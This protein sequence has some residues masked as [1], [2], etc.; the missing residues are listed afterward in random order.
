MI[1]KFKQVVSA[2][3]KVAFDG[4]Y[5]RLVVESTSNIQYLLEF[6]YIPDKKFNEITRFEI[7]NNGYNADQEQ[8]LN[9]IPNNDMYFDA[10]REFILKKYGGVLKD[11]ALSFAASFDTSSNKY[12][13]LAFTSNTQRYE[14]IVGV[15][16]DT[17][18]VSVTRWEK[19]E[20]GYVPVPVANLLN[21]QEFKAVR[22]SVQDYV[23]DKFALE[24]HPQFFEVK[25]VPNES[26]FYKFIF[27]TP[28][29]F[30]LSL[31]ERLSD[32][33]LSVLG[34]QRVQI[35]P[36][37]EYYNDRLFAGFSA[38]KLGNL[39]FDEV[40]QN[41][42][43]AL[44]SRF[45]VSESN[46]QPLAAF[47]MSTPVGLAYKVVFNYNKSERLASFAYN[48]NEKNYKVV[49]FD[50]FVRQVEEGDYRWKCLS[51]HRTKNVCEKCENNFLLTS[52]R[53]YSPV[54]SCAVQI[55]STCYSCAAGKVRVQ[56]LCSQSPSPAPKPEEKVEKEVVTSTGTKTIGFN[57]GND[58]NCLQYKD[59]LC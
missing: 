11:S 22:Q 21:N 16:K 45:G 17:K 12:Y 2:E 1:S 29:P 54:P 8:Q 47:R 9:Q 3:K 37:N 50:P 5:Y 51:L 27:D 24:A 59:S 23:K 19:L 28:F 40:Y 38:V 30:E 25:N 57:V 33:K 55:A 15:N 56:G 41:F 49:S 43:S 14:C 36:T 44:K 20:N 7:L 39:Q 46:C 58:P 31:E 34:M 35:A 26:A 48:F 13:R 42:F 52:G 10:G 6:F 53:C 18:A 4:I 32:H